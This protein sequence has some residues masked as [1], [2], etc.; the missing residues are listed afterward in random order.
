LFVL[1]VGEIKFRKTRHSNRKCG[2]VNEER[3]YILAKNTP[4]FAIGRRNSDFLNG[5]KDNDTAQDV[6]RSP[7][8]RQGV[9]YFHDRPA[10]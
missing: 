4:D 1:C 10:G 8:T 5:A 6:W 2:T 7:F 3:G 9:R